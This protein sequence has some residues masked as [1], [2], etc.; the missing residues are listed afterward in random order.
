MKRR[1]NSLPT[2]HLTVSNEFR[3]K[4]LNLA[5]RAERLRHPFLPFGGF[6]ILKLVGNRCAMAIVKFRLTD[7]LLNGGLLFY[8]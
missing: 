2:G 5:A 3:M 8:G 1:Q 6:T 4:L 7:G